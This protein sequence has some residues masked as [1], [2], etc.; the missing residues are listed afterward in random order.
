MA[1]CVATSLY[2]REFSQ[3][4]CSRRRDEYYSI[5]D[6]LAILSPLDSSIGRAGRRRAAR[7]DGS[8][9]AGGRAPP[10]ARRPAVVGG[11]L[12]LAYVRSYASVGTQQAG[13]VSW[14]WQL[15]TVC[16]KL[17]DMSRLWQ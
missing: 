15:L 16:A 9:H 11:S 2:R 1:A 13:V 17:S 8:E 10:R 3:F 7:A 12:A 5:I 4:R 14:V 6:I